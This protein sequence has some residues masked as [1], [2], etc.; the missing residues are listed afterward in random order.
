MVKRI[1]DIV[2]HQLN[3]YKKE[4][5]LAYKVDG[6]WKTF[7]SADFKVQADF[8]S[9]GLLALGIKKDDKIAIIAANRPEWNFADIGVQQIGA[10]LVP[11]YT[12]VSSSDYKF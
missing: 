8:M 12:S 1:F 11:M 5:A 6:Q 7:S 2:E 4:I 3:I 10:V 9:S